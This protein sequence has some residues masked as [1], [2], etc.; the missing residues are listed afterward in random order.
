MVDNFVQ[1]R[2]IGFTGHSSA[3]IFGFIDMKG[4]VYD[5][6]AGRFLSPDIFLRP[7]SEGLNRLSYARNSPLMRVDPSG[8]VDEEAPKPTGKYVT[9][10]SDGSWVSCNEGGTDCEA[11]D[12]SS[13]TVVINDSNDA[14]SVVYSTPHIEADY[15]PRTARFI[16]EMDRSLDRAT[17]QAGIGYLM[18][19]PFGNSII[20]AHDNQPLAGALALDIAFIV[21]WMRLIGMSGSMIGHALLPD[22]G[23]LAAVGIRSFEREWVAASKTTWFGFRPLYGPHQI[24]YGPHQAP[25]CGPFKRSPRPGEPEIVI[26]TGLQGGTKGVGTWGGG[27]ATVRAWHSP[28]IVRSNWY[29][30]YTYSEPLYGTNQVSWGLEQGAFEIEGM[31]DMVFIEVF[32]VGP[33]K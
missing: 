7:D 27:V 9:Y 20:A 25:V 21:P 29:E 3:D 18:G 12:P 28:P 24:M 13:Y 22:I 19:L 11:Y 5:P 33:V 32:G 31:G 15:N 4:R 10:F 2:S 30:F 17:K 6:Y 26:A 23:E 8:F 1:T 14:E 16:H